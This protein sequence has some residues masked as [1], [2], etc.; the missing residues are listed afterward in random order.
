[1]ST[2][3]RS[4]KSPS[5]SSRSVNA[6]GS[7]MP[8]VPVRPVDPDVVVLGQRARLGDDRLG[9]GCDIGQAVETGRQVLDGAHPGCLVGDGPI[10]ARVA[11]GDRRLVG[12]R[13]RQRDLLARP[14]RGPRVVEAEQAHRPSLA[15]AAP[16]RRSGCPPPRRPCGAPGGLVGVRLV[17]D[18][19]APLAQRADADRV[20]V[21]RDAADRGE[22]LAAEA[23]HRGLAEGMLES[24]MSHRPALSASNSERVRVTMSSSTVARSSWPVSS[25]VTWRRARERLTS[26]RARART[27]AFRMSARNRAGHIAQEGVGAS[28]PSGPPG[29]SSR[30]SSPIRSPAARSVSWARAPSLRRLTEPASH[31]EADQAWPAAGCGS[32]RGSRARGS[33]RAP[34]A[35]GRWRP[36]RCRGW[37][38][39]PRSRCGRPRSGWPMDRCP[40]PGAE[41]GGFDL[42]PGGAAVVRQ[43]DVGGVAAFGEQ[44]LHVAATVAAVAAGV[45]A[46]GRQPARIGP[47]AQ[48][49]RVD[50][51]QC[52][53]LGDADQPVKIVP[54]VARWRGHPVASHPSST[55]GGSVRNR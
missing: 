24:S 26:R 35:P 20:R 43:G 42:A 25:W 7:Q 12:E 23:V 38:A 11:D 46:I 45:D 8:L 19:R 54:P 40:A 51:E 10:Q 2:R 36:V 15:T 1:M 39:A 52:R 29:S 9:D 32:R 6:I 13:L 50:A 14:A 44:E 41:D 47:G 22:E 18:E 49:V 21:P 4:R 33:G 3:S 53:S 31:G 16:G 30:T 28:R 5:P 27:L 37:C 48:G 55:N 34:R 17:H